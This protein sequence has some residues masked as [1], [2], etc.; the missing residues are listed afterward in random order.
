MLPVPLRCQTVPSVIARYVNVIGCWTLKRV[1]T[2]DVFIEVR[3][4]VSVIIP[5]RVPGRRRSKIKHFPPIGQAI[6]IGI[7][8][9]I[10]PDVYPPIIEPGFTININQP[11]V[12]PV[13]VAR[14]KA[15]RS[16]A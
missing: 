3:S 13:R 8:E 11:L 10:G 12:V 9:L 2:P 4:T 15:G 7:Q 5:R 6:R 16:G 1:A 14:V